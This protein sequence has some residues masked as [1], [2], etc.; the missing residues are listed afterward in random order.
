LKGDATVPEGAWKGEGV[1]P[2]AAEG[3]VVGG[4]LCLLGDTL[5]TPEPLDCEGKILI[6]E[7]VDEQPHRVDAM[8][9]HLR[10]CGVIQMAAGIVF[11]EMTRTDDKVDTKIGG[12]PW[13]KIVEDRVADL[14]IPTMVNYPFGHMKQMLSLPLG[15]RARLD[16]DA[17]TL[18]Y[19]ESPCA[20]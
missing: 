1:V 4:C 16:A 18:T 9:T 19:V 14:G 17:G 6:I 2:G 7:D 12:W 20:T 13:R 10:N 3:I 5:G 15:I 11:G 8:L